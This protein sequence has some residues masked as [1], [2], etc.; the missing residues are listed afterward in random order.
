MRSYENLIDQLCSQFEISVQGTSDPQ[1]H[2][3]NGFPP[4]LTQDEQ[5][6][7]VLGYHQMRKWLWMNRDSRDEW[8]AVHSDAPKAYLWNKKE[9]VD[10]DDAT[11]S[12]GEN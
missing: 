11:D 8:N 6:M 7:F 4:I 1:A 3:K 5:G 10:V 12:K 9:A 2:F